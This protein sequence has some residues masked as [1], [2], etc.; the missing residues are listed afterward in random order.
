ME[1]STNLVTHLRKELTIVSHFLN[2]G[3][4]LGILGC[5]NIALEQQYHAVVGVFASM[6]DQCHNHVQI[7]LGPGFGFLLDL[8]HTLLEGGVSWA[9]NIIL[10][11]NLG[12][13]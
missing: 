6:L 9:Q 11:S 4:V 8:F 3:K 1:W 13:V 7:N 10:V 5:I 2:G 12:F